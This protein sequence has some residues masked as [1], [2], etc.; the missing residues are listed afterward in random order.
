MSK[1]FFVLADARAFVLEIERPFDLG[2]LPE[3]LKPAAP[4]SPAAATF[5]T[6]ADVLVS[7]RDE[8]C[9]LLAEPVVQTKLRAAG[10]LSSLSY[11]GIP[12][13]TAAK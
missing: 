12:V 6:L 7:Y 8:A 11:T 1:T 2:E 5:A 3:D 13:K 9:P 10:E 4:P